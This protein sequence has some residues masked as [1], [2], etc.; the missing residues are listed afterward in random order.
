MSF[1]TSPL[2]KIPSLK[3]NLKIKLYIPCGI[4]IYFKV[5]SLQ[6]DKYNAIFCTIE[7]SL[8]SPLTRFINFRKDKNIKE[9]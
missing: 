7:L 8:T 9:S 3:L 2:K 5:K 4:E 6:I 1:I